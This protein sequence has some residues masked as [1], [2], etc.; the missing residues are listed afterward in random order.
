MALFARGDGIV[1]DVGRR[2]PPRRP[3]INRQDARR[4]RLP[5]AR[6]SNSNCGRSSEKVEQLEKDGK[7]DEAE[8]LKHEARE[9]MTK[10]R[11]GSATAPQPAVSGPEA[12]KIRGQLQEIEPEGRPIGQRRQARRGPTPEAARPGHST[13]RSIR[14]PAPIAAPGGPER[15]Q[16]H[17]QMRRSMKR[18]KRQ[19]RRASPMKSSD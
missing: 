1:D 17:Q 16:L 12:E 6:R 10:L 9:I 18:S 15:E 14:V 13:A 3:A 7:H 8:K 2:P 11:G 5:T 4:R 19:P